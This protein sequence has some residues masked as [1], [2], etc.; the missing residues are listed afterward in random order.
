VDILRKIL[1]SIEERRHKEMF[2]KIR[3]FLKGKKTYLVAVGLII[4]AVVEYTN[5]NDLA[6]L[7]DKILKALALMT[8]RAAISKV[9][10][11]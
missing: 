1:I 2:D 8:V 7:V 5:D 4:E 3:E 9:E 11:K 6:K 10:D